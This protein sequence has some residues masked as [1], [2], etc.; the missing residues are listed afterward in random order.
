[1]MMMMMKARD[2]TLLFF[3]F[4]GAT[5]KAGRGCLILEVSR[6]HRI[7]HTHVSGSTPLGE[8]SVR[9]GDQYTLI[10]TRRQQ[11]GRCLGVM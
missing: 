1:M 8:G 11:Q 3:S 4:C 2:S 6:S 10:V 9:R 5:A 7:S